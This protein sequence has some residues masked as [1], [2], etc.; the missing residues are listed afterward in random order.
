MDKTR[1]F[2]SYKNTDADGKVLRDAFLAEE[3]YTELSRRGINTFYSSKSIK[4]LG[5]ANYKIAIDNAL[6]EA[7]VLV[8]IGTSPDNLNSNWVNYMRLKRKL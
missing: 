1:V 3:L 5:E 4:R 6:D 2:L 7:T 8:A